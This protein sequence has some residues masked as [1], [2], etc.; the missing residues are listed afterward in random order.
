VPAADAQPE[1]QP[2]EPEAY[3][4]AREGSEEQHYCFVTGES[5]NESP[6]RVEAIF[7]EAGALKRAHFLSLGYFVY[8]LQQFERQGRALSVHKV[9]VVDYAT[10]GTP[11]EHLVEIDRVEQNVWFVLT[12]RKVGKA[13]APY[14]YAF[15]SEQ[16]AED[17]VKQHGGRVQAYE[18]VL[19]KIARALN[20][21]ES[22]KGGEFARE[23]MN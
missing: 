2:G 16:S 9:S 19:T 11:G 8:A 6:Q 4:D 7:R 14:V 21:D 15:E 12:D 22:G 18:T 1:D 17:F 10:L 20:T 13:R 5:W 3:I 23:L